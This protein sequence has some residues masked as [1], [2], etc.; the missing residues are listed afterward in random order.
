MDFLDIGDFIIKVITILFTLT[1]SVFIIDIMV[2]LMDGVFIILITVLFIVLFTIHI[3]V[4]I[5][6]HFIDLFTIL[7]ITLMTHFMLQEDIII[8][9]IIQI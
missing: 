9:N 7:F 1:G 4:H 2:L 5:I 3:I 6:R 8:D